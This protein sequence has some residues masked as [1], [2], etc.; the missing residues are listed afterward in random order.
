MKPKRN[1]RLNHSGRK[2]RPVEKVDKEQVATM[3][4]EVATLL[5]L[6]G[7]STFEV[8]AYQNGARAIEA[9][10]GDIEDIVK[11]GQIASMHGV[12]TGRGA[13]ITEHVT[14]GKMDLYK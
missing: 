5:E 6:T 4:E 1:G 13:T 8:R 7:S 11:S 14:T 9:L 10:E 3:L 12:I 2:V